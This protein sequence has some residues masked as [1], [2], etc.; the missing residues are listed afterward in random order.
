[1][2]NIHTLNDWMFTLV[3][4]IQNKDQMTID[5]LNNVSAGWLQTSDERGAQLSLLEA[6]SDLMYEVL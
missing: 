3:E 4:A 2:N 1:M 5:E 6:V